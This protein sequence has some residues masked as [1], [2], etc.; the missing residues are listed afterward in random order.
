MK[1]DKKKKKSEKEVRDWIV[2]RFDEN[3][4]GL[5]AQW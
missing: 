4:L 1:V 2:H 5:M 3:G